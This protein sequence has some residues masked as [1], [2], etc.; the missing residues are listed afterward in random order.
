MRA[1]WGLEGR[2]HRLLGA[3]SSRRRRGRTEECAARAFVE[4]RRARKRLSRVQLSGLWR[5]GSA[6]RGAAVSLASTSACWRVLAGTFALAVEA[7]AAGVLAEVDELLRGGPVG[8]DALCAAGGLGAEVGGVVGGLDALGEGLV[9]GVLGLGLALLGGLALDEGAEGLLLLDG[10]AR[11]GGVELGAERDEGRS[12]DG[13]VGEGGLAGGR[14]LGGGGGVE[15]SGRLLRV[16]RL[17][18]GLVRRGRRGVVVRVLGRLDGRR[19]LQ[20]LRGEPK[21]PRRAS[22]GSC[23]RGWAHAR[24]EPRPALRRPH[25]SDHAHGRLH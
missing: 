2:L 8:G 16:G 20:M 9:V 4:P 21:R 1:G 14:L 6:A 22:L 10:V 25:R 5:G 11:E 15:G 17:R 19:R 13:L 12:L 3:E 23:A 18:L 7:V 24:R